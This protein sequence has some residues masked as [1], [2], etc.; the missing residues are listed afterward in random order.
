MIICPYPKTIKKEWKTYSKRDSTYKTAVSK[1]DSIQEEY[2]Q[3][4][5]HVA[6]HAEK[7]EFPCHR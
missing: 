7:T 1:Y 5:Q 3:I 4:V 2:M 6:A